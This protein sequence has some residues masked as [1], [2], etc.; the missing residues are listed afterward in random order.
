MPAPP[1]PRKEVPLVGRTVS[2]D[3][4]LPHPGV[5]CTNRACDAPKPGRTSAVA[6]RILPQGADT[7]ASERGRSP[8]RAPGLSS[9]VPDAEAHSFTLTTLGN[10]VES[11]NACLVRMRGVVNRGI[12]TCAM[13]PPPLGAGRG[14]FWKEERNREDVGEDQIH[15][16]SNPDLTSTNPD[17]HVGRGVT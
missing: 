16:L 10:R 6:L 13:H 17:R 8:R 5:G 1:Q 15:A 3:T 11:G 12:S 4:I 9:G 14:M 2:R 7:H